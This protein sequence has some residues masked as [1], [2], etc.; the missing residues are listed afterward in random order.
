MIILESILLQLT[1]FHYFLLL[2]SIPLYICTISSLSIFFVLVGHLS[3]FRVLATVSSAAVSTE[4]HVY[5]QIMV[6]SRYM[7]SSRTVGSYG[8]SSFRFLRNLHTSL[9]S[10]MHQLTFPPIG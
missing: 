3:C 2:S 6:F 5:F 8:N 1:L 4:D 9:Y 10:T 7:P